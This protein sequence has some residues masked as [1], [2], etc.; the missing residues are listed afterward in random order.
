MLWVTETCLL[1][2]LPTEAIGFT[3]LL[4]QE[5]AGKVDFSYPGKVLFASYQHLHVQLWQVCSL[6]IVEKGE[7][8]NI[9]VI[10]HLNLYS[11]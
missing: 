9:T 11:L 7:G 10:I 4:P 3:L 5:E 6:C 1:C 2:P 8:G